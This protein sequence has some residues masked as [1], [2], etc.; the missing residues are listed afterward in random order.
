MRFIVG[1]LS[2]SPLEQQNIFHRPVDRSPI[3]LAEHLLQTNVISR[4]K[5]TRERPFVLGSFVR[6]DSILLG[7]RI[8]ILD[9]VKITDYDMKEKSFID[10]ANLSYKTMVFLW[11]RNQQA[12]LLEYRTD[13]HKKPEKLLEQLESHLNDSLVEYGLY[14]KIWVMPEPEKFWQAIERFRK[15]YRVRFRLAMPNLFGDTLKPLRDTLNDIRGSTNATEIVTELRNDAGRIKINKDSKQLQDA[16]EWIDKGGGEWSI[17]GDTPN[18]RKVTIKSTRTSKKVETKWE[19][20]NFNTEE[21][22]YLL[23]ELA[24]FYAYDKDG[25]GGES[26]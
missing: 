9:D 4:S 22:A 24:P 15:I 1:R 12:I 6:N 11:D 13:V 17:T 21:F 2:F 26:A 25:K 3:E 16:A 7:G 19:L 18:A 10:L 23:K 14:V 5:S 8:G 20:V